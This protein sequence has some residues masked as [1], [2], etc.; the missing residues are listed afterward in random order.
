MV[1]AE[2]FKIT[3]TSAKL[4]DAK[5]RPIVLHLQKK[6]IKTYYSCQGHP[7]R[8]NYAAHGYITYKSDARTTRRFKKAGFKIVKGNIPNTRIAE[9]S[10][11]SKKRLDAKW[12]KALKY[13]K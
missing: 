12:R 2:Y 8:R 10:S 3:K 7:C 11:R 5:V 4:L 13:L 9:T 6:G 1:T